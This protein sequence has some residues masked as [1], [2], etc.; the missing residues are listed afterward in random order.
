MFSTFCKQ[1]ILAIK[2]PLKK[3]LYGS[4]FLEF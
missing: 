3:N 1:H 4:C 2:N